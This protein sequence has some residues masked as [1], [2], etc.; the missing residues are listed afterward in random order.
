MR[1]T[2]RNCRQDSLRGYGTVGTTCRSTR[3]SR[4]FDYTIPTGVNTPS[5]RRKEHYAASGH[6]GSPIIP[7]R[8]R[9]C[10]PRW[11]DAASL[12]QEIR[13]SRRYPAGNQGAYLTMGLLVRSLEQTAV[14]CL[15]T[16]VGRPVTGPDYFDRLFCRQQTGTNT[17]WKRPEFDEM[18]LSARGRVG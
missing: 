4:C 7:A 2:R 9:R 6:D 14:L 17:R 16:G 11:V 13:Q 10:L 15:L 3:P 1:S 5:R 12:F 18:L 8:F